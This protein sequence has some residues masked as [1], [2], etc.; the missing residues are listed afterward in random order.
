MNTIIVIINFVSGTFYPFHRL[1]SIEP[2]PQCCFRGGTLVWMD[3]FLFYNNNYWATARVLVHF[4]CEAVLSGT[5]LVVNT[6]RN[7]TV[8]SLFP[9]RSKY[10]IIVI[11]L[12]CAFLSE[13]V[14]YF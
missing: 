9:E 6:L 5:Y 4:C 12:V 7:A 11:I 10:S 14:D 2:R 13:S 1:C 8:N 3:Q